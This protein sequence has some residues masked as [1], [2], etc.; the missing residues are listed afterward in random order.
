MSVSRW[1]RVRLAVVVVLTL[2]SQAAAQDGGKYRLPGDLVP[3]SYVLRMV[4]YLE[5][6][7]MRF[8]GTVDITVNATTDT[9]SITLHAHK[10][11]EVK[12]VGLRDWDTQEALGIGIVS[13]K[14]DYEFL[15]IPV[16][17]VLTANKKYVLSL[18]FQSHLRTDNYG[19]YVSS[20]A[21]RDGFEYVGIFIRREA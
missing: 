2:A 9:S 12:V 21:V 5:A 15:I 1:G 17:K 14:E 11:L 4:P 19:F 16:T 18:S 7:N 8:T 6:G 10:D 13:A 3:E 20:Y